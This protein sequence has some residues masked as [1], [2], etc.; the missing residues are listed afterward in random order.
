MTTPESENMS[1]PKKR[2]LIWRKMF[3]DDYYP[4]QYS[5]SEADFLHF[6]AR[7]DYIGDF[8]KQRDI[9]PLQITYSIGGDRINMANFDSIDEGMAWLTNKLKKAVEDNKRAL[10]LDQDL[11]IEE[12]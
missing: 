7:I 10:E 4:G 8:E 11:Q 5:A 12:P 6:N 1:A 2:T 3:T 9:S